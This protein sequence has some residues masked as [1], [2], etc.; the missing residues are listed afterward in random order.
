MVCM[1]WKS[2]ALI[3]SDF[4]PPNFICQA[5]MSTCGSIT[6]NGIQFAVTFKWTWLFLAKCFDVWLLKLFP[7]LS[8][9]C[10]KEAIN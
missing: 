3:D 9:I 8:T 4:K 7:T 5:I 1:E 10:L 2:L 6:E